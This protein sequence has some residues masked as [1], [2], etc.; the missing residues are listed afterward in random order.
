MENIQNYD[1]IKEN[2]YIEKTKKDKSLLLKFVQDL[3]CT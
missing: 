1:E 2:F 3:N